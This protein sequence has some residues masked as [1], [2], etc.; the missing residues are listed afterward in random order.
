MLLPQFAIVTTI[1]L[2]VK[3]MST[4]KIELFTFDTFIVTENNRVHYNTAKKLA[5]DPDAFRLTFFNLPAQ[6]A[7]HLKHS[8]LRFW[9][10][11]VEWGSFSTYEFVDDLI[12]DIRNDI[13]PYRIQKYID[14]KV[15]ILDDIQYIMGKESTQEEL[16]RILKMRLEKSKVTILFSACDIENIRVL[17]RDDMY[18]LLTLA[19][20]DDNE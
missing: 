3:K 8:L 17:L 15:L 11:S 14:P 2:G 7:L 5:I 6:Q 18:N 20:H 12:F 10:S 4:D 9:K 13:Y 1:H 16:Y 19:T